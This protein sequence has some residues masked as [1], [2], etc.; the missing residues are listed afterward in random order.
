MK[1]TRTLALLLVLAAG[2]PLPA[3][4]QQQPQN[5]PAAPQAGAQGFLRARHDVVNRILRR[6]ARTPADQAR[7]RQE[8]GRALA[9][10]LDYDELSRQSLASHWGQHSEAERREF[11]A[12]LRQLVE[13]SYQHNLRSTLDFD[14]RYLSEDP[15]QGGAV[16][17]RTTA[18]SRTQ[19]RAPQ[20]A[21]DYTLKRAG[22]TWRVYDVTTDGVSLVRNYRAQFNRIIQREGWPALIQRM[23]SRLEAGSEI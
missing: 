1:I 8:L 15:A 5:G 19:R 16:V 23:R 21:I 6:P 14:I 20:V 18:R 17:V 9:D 2:A 3:L 22:T 7:V 13:Q 12:L 10:L 11:V 4:A